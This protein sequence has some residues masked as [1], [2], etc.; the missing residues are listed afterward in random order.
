MIEALRAAV[1]ECVRA[2]HDG[3]GS[4][5]GY[6]PFAIIEPGSAG[7]AATAITVCASRGWLVIP[8]GAATWL[9]PVRTYDRPFVLVSTVK[10]NTIEDYRP[11]D[12]TVTVGAGVTIDALSKAAGEKRQWVALDP[13]H[14]SGA[15]IGGLVATA[16]AG[17][18]RA[19][20]GTPRDHVL[21]LEIITGDG[22]VL[23]FGGQVVKNVAGYDLV[24]PIT[25]SRGTLGL[26]TRVSLRLRP[27]H[28][29]DETIA[30]AFDMADVNAISE[31]VEQAWPVAALE[32][33][34]P[35][36]AAEVAGH[37]APDHWLMMI[38]LHGHDTEV[39]EGIARIN[40]V[41]AHVRGAG[42]PSRVVAACWA[43]LSR[44]EARTSYHIRFA[45]K[46]SVLPQTIGIAQRLG[47]KLF[48]EHSR[49][50]CHA[51]AGVVRLWSDGGA[52]T[53]KGSKDDAAAVLDADTAIRAVDG[54]LHSP[55]PRPPSNE[56]LA[57]INRDI[58]RLFDPAG[59]LPGSHE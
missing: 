6:M 53:G 2:P 39:Q 31:A 44:T 46:S 57:Q 24:R 52:A 1:G 56:K 40:S 33:L 22:R 54:T 12:L 14:E 32:I 16:S 3:E 21:G 9:Q 49:I 48:G 38:R 34:S 35:A 25:G 47:E 42:T 28:A 43:A 4:V 59:I 19:R 15:T 8:A 20:Y 36:L 45:A 26:I 5:N 13:P 29:S 51:T 37:S 41:L 30:F 23:H 27:L 17:P 55:S 11:E 50:A 10:L 58:I 18:L 7:D